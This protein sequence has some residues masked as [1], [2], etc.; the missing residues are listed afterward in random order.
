M[1][2]P[3]CFLGPTRVHTPNGVSVGSTVFEPKQVTKVK[4]RQTDLQTERERDIE[5]TI[6]PSVNM[7]YPRRPITAMQPNTVNEA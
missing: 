1:C 4:D 2:T 5:I 6:H 7:L 3:T